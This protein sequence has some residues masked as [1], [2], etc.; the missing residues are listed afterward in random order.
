M[1]NKL[2]CQPFFD[3][4]EF[5]PHYFEVGQLSCVGALEIFPLPSPGGKMGSLW[6]S[7]LLFSLGVSFFFSLFSAFSGLR[8]LSHRIIIRQIRLSAASLHDMPTLACGASLAIRALGS[9]N[10]F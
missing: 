7:L 4:S 1:P 10:N 9:P 2:R 8:L 6:G 3:F 5:T